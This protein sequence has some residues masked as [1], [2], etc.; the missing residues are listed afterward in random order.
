[1]SLNLIEKLAEC[2]SQEAK[3]IIQK[4][5][6]YNNQILA[7]TKNVMIAANLCIGSKALSN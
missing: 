7:T 3:R 4:E 1:M 5:H 2:T 6:N